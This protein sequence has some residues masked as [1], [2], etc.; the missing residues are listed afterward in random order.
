MT[1]YTKIG[2]VQKSIEIM[3][4]M[5]SEVQPVS[6]TEISNAVGMRF[7]TVM[8]HLATLEEG[9]LVQRRYERYELGIF[10]G[11]TWESIKQSRVSMRD[12]A[13]NDL[14]KIGAV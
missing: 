4:F 10:W 14:A 2:A 11:V 7:H 1:S 6:P 9:G 5:A 12:S 3:K 8:S 13:N